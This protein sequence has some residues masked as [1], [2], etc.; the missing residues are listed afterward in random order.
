MQVAHTMAF[1]DEHCLMHNVPENH[2]ECPERVGDLV[3]LIEELALHPSRALSVQRQTREVED[4][5]LYDVHD[6]AYIDLILKNI[7]L[8]PQEK[9]AM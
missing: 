8:S 5:D 2:F 4:N 1:Y 7:P 3:T 6:H 9:P